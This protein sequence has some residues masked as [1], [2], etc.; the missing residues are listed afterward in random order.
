MEKP[1]VAPPAAHPRSR[2]EHWM[3]PRSR[4]LLLGS[5]PLAR[6]TCELINHR[7]QRL[8]LIPARAGNMQWMVTDV[9]M[10]AAHP[11]SRGEHSL[12]DLAKS[13]GSGSSPLARGTS[14]RQCCCSRRTRLIPA[15]AGNISTQ[16]GRYRPP[17]AHP[18][19]R[20]EHVGGGYVFH[21]WVG[22]S[23][24]ARGT[25]NLVRKEEKMLRLIPARAG[26]MPVASAHSDGSSAHPRS[27]GEHRVKISYASVPAGSSPL[28]RGTFVKL[29][30]PAG[31][32]RLIPARAG[33]IIV[34]P[35][36]NA[37]PK[38]HPRSRGE[39]C[40]LALSWPCSS[41]SSPLARGTF[42]NAFQNGIIPLAHP[43][44]RGEHTC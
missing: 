33:N 28:A 16:S 11:R 24:L 43:R 5:S 29:V 2:G 40:A 26:N 19:S 15:R 3:L 10:T 7:G 34:S 14:L 1:A 41:G 4:M 20:G 42:K 32:A 18:R 13:L 36:S 44:S 39:H 8:R 12:G 9:S 35:T 31:P 37:T 38:A 17:S 27:R 22:S 6:G 25:S 23:P 21:R 30:T